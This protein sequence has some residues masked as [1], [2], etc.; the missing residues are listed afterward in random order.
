FLLRKILAD[1]GLTYVVKDEVIEVVSPQKARSMMSVR[2]YYV[3]DLAANRWQAAVLIDLIQS[4]IEPES[5]RANGGA[6]AL[7]YPPL[8]RSLVIKQTSE[9]HSALS[10]ALR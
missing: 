3:G 8:T 10:G 6:G 4:T 1:L 5:W 7:G 9:F 2:T